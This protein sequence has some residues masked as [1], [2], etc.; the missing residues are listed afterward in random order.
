MKPVGECRF[1]SS[2][3]VLSIHWFAPQEAVKRLDHEGERALV[4]EASREP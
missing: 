2:E 4:T 3:E 1:Q